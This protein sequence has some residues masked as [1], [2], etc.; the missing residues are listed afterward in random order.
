MLILAACGFVAGETAVQPQ[1]ALNGIWLC[2]TLLPSVGILLA[3]AL[4]YFYKLRDKD[5]QIMAQYNDG[6]LTK[7]E[8]DEKLASKYGPA[9]ILT[10]MTVTESV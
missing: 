9:A 6:H 2:Y 1:S 10:K 3:L 8:A 5:V 7:E 4:L